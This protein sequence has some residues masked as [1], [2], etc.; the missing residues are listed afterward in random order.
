MT[1]AAFEE[2]FGG[3]PRAVR[4][5]RITQREMDLAA[6]IQVVTEEIDAAHGA[7]RA[8]ADRRAEPL[9]RR[10]RGAQLRRQRRTAARG[11]FEDIWIQPA[12]GDAGGALG[13]ALFVWHQLLDTAE[14]TPNGGRL[15]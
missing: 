5:S 1:N 9:P 8:R 12:A 7:P 6:L 15:A 11:I 14:R 2:L 10:R 13:A 3:P 4:E